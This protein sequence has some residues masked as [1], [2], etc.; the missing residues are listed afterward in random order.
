MIPISR[1]LH[2]QGNPL[3]LDGVGDDWDPNWR[4][5]PDPLDVFLTDSGNHPHDPPIYARSGYD[6]IAL[7]G[8]YQSADDRWYFRIDVDG[9]AGDADSQ[10][11]TAENLGVGTHG[12]DQ[13]PL[14]LPPFVDGDGLGNSEAYKLG[15]QCAADAA[16]QTAEISNDPTILPGV[17][18]ATTA[19]LDGLGVYSTTVPGVV[20][21]SFDR[22]TL[23][24]AGSTCPEFW[25]SAQIG[26]NND[27]VS[28]DQVTAILVIALDLLAQCP[29]APAVAGDQAT[30]VL[31]YAIPG[32]AQQGATGVVLTVGVP[33]GTKF[34]SAS[35]G[36]TEAGG[37]ITWDLGNLPPGTAGQVTFTVSVASN[38]TEITL[39]SEISS[40]EGLRY[41]S[42]D[43][44]PV[45]QPTRTPPPK[46][47]ATRRPPP[48]TPMTP[49]P[50]G[51]TVQPPSDTTP[52]VP[53]PSTV[54]LLLA[55]LGT[56]A[57][58]AG[59]Q[60]RARRRQ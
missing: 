47:T 31:D 30:F 49:P 35:D 9:R 58:Y 15:F 3:V 24:P 11:G 46:P 22:L 48:G 17:V 5:K 8:H 51:P 42:S 52:L 25:L 45:L 34:I 14:V 40:G 32:D 10:W 16:G 37:F 29:E 53:E 50:A 6:A 55:G 27:R 20:E 12:N 38:V 59:L 41:L 1:P 43:V 60:W 7:W 23:F 18:A 13:G 26:D 54:T 21:F 33:A 2:A 57:G 19:G 56:L 44:C 4:L 28:D 39:D 36:G